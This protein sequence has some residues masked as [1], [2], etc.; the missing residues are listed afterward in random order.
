MQL[1]PN[2]APYDAGTTYDNTINK[3]ATYN[4]YLWKWIGATSGSGVTCGTDATKWERIMVNDMAHAMNHDTILD[5]GGDNEIKAL[6]IPKFVEVTISSADILS[7]N[8]IELPISGDATKFVDI[9]SIT[10]ETLFEATS[11]FSTP[12]DS[13]SLFIKTTDATENMFEFINFF[14]C[15]DKIIRK[16]VQVYSDGAVSQLIKNKTL[17]AVFDS[18]TSPANVTGGDYDIK[19]RIHYLILE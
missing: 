2:I 19:L 14:G 15:T 5:Y 18:G 16:G 4:S 9:T 10:A 1:A 13:G 7:G 12:Y 3:Y 6:H 17:V 8:E 11:P